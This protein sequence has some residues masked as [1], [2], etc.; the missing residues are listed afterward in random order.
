LQLM[1]KETKLSLD[2][3]WKSSD[4]EQ[5]ALRQAKE[6]FDLKETATADATAASRREN[7]MLD[8]MT[9]ASQDMAGMCYV[10]WLLLFMALLSSLSC[11]YFIYIVSSRHFCG[12]CSRRTKSDLPSR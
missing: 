6:S 10:F 8:L 9:D 5:A 3:S 11:C 12:C 4:R 7:Y 1:K 2:Q